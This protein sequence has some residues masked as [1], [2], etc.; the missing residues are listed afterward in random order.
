VN[1]LPALLLAVAAAGGA[2]SPPLLPVPAPDPARME[3]AVR[4]QVEAAEKAV[5][6]AQSPEAFGNA[7][8][9]YLLYDLLDAALPCFENARALGPA[10]FRWPYYLGVLHQ[11]RGDFDRAAGAF[12]EVLRE[13]PDD[14][15]TLLRLGDVELLRQRTD[16]AAKSFTAALRLDPSS[17][18]AHYGLGRTAMAKQ[19]YAAA[20]EQL[21]AALAGQ[22]AATVIHYSLGMAYRRLGQLDRAAA[23]LAG[24]RDVG[25]GGG[26]GAAKFPDPLVDQL[27]S[28]NAGAKRHVALATSALQQG[29]FALAAEEYRKALAGDP[30]DLTAWLNLG[31]ALE[32]LNDSAG[33]EEAYRRAVALAPRNSRARY[34]L[35]TLLAAGG[36]RQEGI[37]QLEAAVALDSGSKDSKDAR[38]NL[39]MA[40]AEAGSFE[41]ALAQYDRLLELDPRDSVV[42]YQRGMTLLR[43]GRAEEAAVELGKVVAAE[44]RAPEPRA[45]QALALLR[46]GRD[47]EAR[48]R[49]EEGL[50]ELPASEDLALLLAK[51]LAASAD[52]KVR[53]GQRAWGLAEAALQPGSTADRE[54]AAALALAEL[55]RFPE[56]ADRERR[57]I[58]LAER[59]GRG[60]LPGMRSRL[61]LYESGKPARAPWR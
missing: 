19:D 51:V 43:L 58:A 25:P 18:A 20:V 40:L 56:A 13:K 44:P 29:R 15:P 21:Q 32:R 52:P 36:K 30:T 11:A 34:N 17:A 9:I 50:A 3:T 49:L 6:T 61:A 14:L 57:A 1:A 5:A 60:D 27:A 47:A 39:A 37:E 48:T 35:G 24:Y 54:E 28:L 7:G 45:G 38:F 33:A 46:A 8:R 2:A 31:A 23:E 42:R 59:A 16:E 4:E 53:D 55:G 26:G 10:D 22:P 12:A 41:R